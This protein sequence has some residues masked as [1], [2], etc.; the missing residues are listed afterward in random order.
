MS[1]FDADLAEGLRR[2]QVRLLCVAMGRAPVVNILVVTFICYIIWG[3][4]APWQA[5]AWA[6]LVL[7]SELVRAAYARKT[8]AK[9]PEDSARALATL[10]RIALFVGCARGSAMPL[11]FASLSEVAND[12]LTV[13]FLGFCAGGLSTHGAHARSFYLFASP[14]LLAMALAW[15]NTG[16]REGV[17]LVILFFLFTAM[18]F[19]FARDIEALVRDSFV[20][21]HQR[22]R[23]VGQLEEERQRVTLARDVAERANDAKSRFLAAASHDLRQPLHAM[24]LFSATLNMR[25][26]GPE[27]QEVA[28]NIG[29]AQRSLSAL[30]DSLLDISKLDARAVR[31]EL[32]PVNIGALARSV[33]AEYRAA[34]QRKGLALEAP[35]GDLT[36]V[37]D[38]LLLERVLR[39]LVDNAIKYTPRGRVGVRLRAEGD[40]V[41]ISVEDTG[42]GIPVEERERVFEEFY[43][44]G[45]PERDRTKG[46]G[47]GLAIVRRIATLLGSEVDLQS[48]IGKG[49]T[50]TFRLPLSLGIPKPVE[51]GAPDHAGSYAKLRERVVLVIDDEPDVRVAMRSL[52]EAWGC[53]V[54]VCG[55]L[56]EAAKLLDEHPVPIDLLVADFRLRAGESGIA[57]IAELRRRLGPVPALLITGDTAPDRLRE[58]QASGL[59]LLHKPLSAD[60]L[61]TAML[62]ALAA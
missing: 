35:E 55:A 62:A 29:S 2:E 15:L 24:S 7:T 32:Q 3:Y 58:A 4:V 18:I 16:T 9:P 54:L 22:D 33:V 37:S 20:I 47:L 40:Q 8:L 11:F 61:R 52:L 41:R 12:A 14:M 25:A 59:P 56:T 30:V 43:Q 51:S 5:L 1:E 17:V 10:G 31:V 42:E 44:I 26:S 23:L 57:T 53:R 34:A 19:V 6:A 60:E 27:L 13:A 48:E 36:V 45:N 21:R 28:D 49:S 39:N 38:P 50:F 46:L